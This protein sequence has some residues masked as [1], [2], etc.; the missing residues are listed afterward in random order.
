MVGSGTVQEGP[1]V[2]DGD[3]GGGGPRAGDA[4]GIIDDTGVIHYVNDF[5][6]G[7]FG[8]A[9]EDLVGTNFVELTHPDDLERN[10]EM[11]VTS[12]QEEEGRDWFSPPVLSRARHQ[13]GTYRFVTVTGSVVART[14]D[15]VFLS[16]LLRPAD[17]FV[18]MHAALQA[19]VD[20][21]ASDQVLDRILQ[22][23]RW[24][25]DRPFVCLAHRVGGELTMV[26]DELPPELD[27][28]S[29]SPGS[30]WE[31]AWQG[32]SFRGTADDLPG[33]LRAV[34]AEH[35]VHA[36]WIRPVQRA[37]HDVA[38]VFTLWYP[39]TGRSLLAW[40][41]TIDFMVDA[42]SVALAY[43]DQ[44]LQLEHSAHH[45]ALTGLPNR[46]AFLGAITD[47]ATRIHDSVE[48]A[49][50]CVLTSTSTVRR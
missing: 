4:M 38:A 10:I 36:F 26:G 34:A 25:R 44:R 42:T 15:R 35:G 7:Y 19:T 5:G 18:A 27:G 28:A 13:D 37:G 22:I 43:D 20:A 9:P 12:A 21:A 46:R 40:E 6:A 23:I 49:R 2:V 29:F 47:L 14:D 11:M 16:V 17:D 31:R 32:E 45:D 30:P 24:Q 3:A 1:T 50:P 8:F 39:S 33:D 48:A 41:L